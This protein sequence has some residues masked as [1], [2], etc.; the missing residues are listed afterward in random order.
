[1]ADCWT[2]QLLTHRN[3]YTGLTY[4]ED[5]VVAF[6]E[7]ANEDSLFG[8]MLNDGGLNYLPEV[9]GSVPR[10]TARAGAWRVVP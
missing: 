7:I 8:T 1:M 3:A 2:R 6:I 10:R 9:S 4:A 5:P